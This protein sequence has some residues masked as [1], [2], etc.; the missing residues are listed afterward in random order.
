MKAF[1]NLVLTYLG[2][3]RAPS[4]YCWHRSLK[5]VQLLWKLPPLTIHKHPKIIIRFPKI[6]IKYARFPGAVLAI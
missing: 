3:G 6:Q 4:R 2:G 1:Q 5:Y